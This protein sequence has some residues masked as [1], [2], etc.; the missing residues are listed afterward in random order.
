MILLHSWLNTGQN[1]SDLYIRQTWGK[2]KR[3]EYV[4][5]M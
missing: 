3:T 4:E 5:T 2:L 1:L